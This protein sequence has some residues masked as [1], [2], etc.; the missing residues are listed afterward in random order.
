M[1]I[2]RLAGELHAEFLED[3]DVH[4]GGMTDVCAWQPASFG[5][6]GH[7]QSCLR[8]VRGAG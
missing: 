7:S 6:L 3:L 5:K 2:N 4:V 1:L 8:V